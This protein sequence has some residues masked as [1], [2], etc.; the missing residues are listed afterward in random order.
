MQLQ[1]WDPLPHTTKLHLSGPP[2]QAPT[3][4]LS[5]RNPFPYQATGTL[6]SPWAGSVSKKC[7]GGPD[8][9]DAVPR[10]RVWEV[11]STYL[12]DQ[13]QRQQPTLGAG[14]SPLPGMSA[15]ASWAAASFFH[16]STSCSA[17]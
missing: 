2:Q 5:R 6:S 3:A 14:G 17:F 11:G 7:G 15:P 1:L 13:T 16:C 10:T 12:Q 9:W 8:L 4:G